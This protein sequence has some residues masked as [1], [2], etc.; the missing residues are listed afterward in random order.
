MSWEVRWL[1]IDATHLDTRLN[2]KLG[3][4]NSVELEQQHEVSWILFTINHFSIAQDELVPHVLEDCSVSW[5]RDT[6]TYRPGVLRSE[7]QTTGIPGVEQ[8][9]HMPSC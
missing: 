1:L 5:D 2:I 6:F 8:T 4:N 7:S 9:G 3:Q